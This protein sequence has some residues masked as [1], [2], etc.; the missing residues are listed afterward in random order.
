MTYRIILLTIISIDVLIL[1]FQ[2]STL[3]IS[4]HEASLLYG[5]I[6]LVQYI[7]NVSLGIF[8]HN[9][10]ALRFPMILLH[11]ISVVLLYL[12]SEKYLNDERNRIWLVLIFILLPG[13]LSSALLVDSAGFIIFG[14]LLFVYVVENFSIKHT[15]PLLVVFS[16]VDGVFI[17]LFISLVAYSLYS[18]NKSFLLI[19]IALLLTSFYLYGIKA[20]GSPEGHLIDTVGL[21]SA[22]FTPVIF[23]YIFY[24]LYRRFLTKD[25]NILWFI[26]SIPLLISL[27]LSFR[28]NINIEN[29]APYL[30]IALPLAAQSFYAAYRVRLKMFRGR[31]KTIFALSALFLSINFI[32]V[33]FNRELYLVIENPKKHFARKMHIAKELSQELK[34]REITCISTTDKMAKRL[35][36]YGVTNCKDNILIEKSLDYTGEDSVTISYKYRPIYKA[37]VTN[38]NNK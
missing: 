30:I 28:Q 4:S 23:I 13:V 8:G 16:L 29:F 26:A 37:V 12:I 1:F 33:L 9:D 35:Q 14:L 17:Y 27:L 20:E 5:P 34:N 21:Y 24:T 11:F 6:S 18:K 2:T 32:V 19:N 31:Y 25:I 15:Y 7:T 10:I 38:L 36:F 22:I 3:S